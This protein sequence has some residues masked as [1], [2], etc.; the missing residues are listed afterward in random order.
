MKNY[1]KQRSTVSP[2]PMVVDDF[3]VW[4]HSDIVPVEEA[5]GEETFI[6][7]EFSMVQYDKDEYIKEMSEK[8]QT[9]EAQLSDT[10]LALVEIYE[11]MV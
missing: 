11:G 9:M 1:G 2:D 5:V 3:S 6:G 7:F 4:I 10:Q 8:N